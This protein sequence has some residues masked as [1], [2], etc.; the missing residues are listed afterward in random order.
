MV[1]VLIAAA[2]VAAIGGATSFAGSSPSASPTTAAAATPMD[3]RAEPAEPT[4]AVESD[5]GSVIEGDVLEL[6][7]V[8]NYSYLRLGAKG[9]NGTEG[10]WAA[11]STASVKVGDHARV[12]G[13]TKMPGFTST[14]LKRTFATIYFGTLDAG[15]GAR[16]VGPA[17]G[18]HVA[19]A[20]DPFNAPADPHAGGADPHQGMSGSATIE[21][22]KV[23]RASGPNGK[24]V[25]EVLGQRVALAGKTIRVQA[26]VVKSTTGVLGRTYLHVRDG[27]G[28]A[29]AGTHDLTV[30]TTATP[31]VGAVITL[32]GVVALDRA[33]GAGYT[34]PTLIE[35]AKVL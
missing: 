9:A 26:T 30:T 27:S 15:G 14:T 19:G 31:A 33:I 2:S 22:K 10:T 32:E 18:H 12:S 7:N 1:Y 24:T 35:D 4:E 23:D 3:P 34:F 5:L 13:A 17:D 21:V 25:A 8:P 16:G 20:V 11:V 6:I 29:T 28:D